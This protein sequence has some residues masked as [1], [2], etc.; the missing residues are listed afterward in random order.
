MATINRLSKDIVVKIPVF[1]AGIT[2]TFSRIHFNLQKNK[3]R[4]PTICLINL[5][6]KIP[7]L[8]KS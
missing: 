1:A 3:L 6:M 4:W 8:G 5:F 7:D 2:R